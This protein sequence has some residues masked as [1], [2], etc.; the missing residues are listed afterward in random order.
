MRA[1][2]AHREAAHPAF[3]ARRIARRPGGHAALASAIGNRA[4]CALIARDDKTKTPA[5]KAR[6][7]NYALA[8]KQNKSYGQVP[9]EAAPW[10]LGWVGKLATVAPDLDALW[11]AGQANEFADAVAALQV[12][13][14]SKGK[15]VD[16]VLGPT[17]W[18][19]LAGLGEG[20]ASL[21]VVENTDGLCYMATQRRFEGGTARATGKKFKLPKGATKKTFDTII[22]THAGKLM[23]IEEQYR[24]TGAAGA[25]VYSG[26]GTF[27]SETD[28][29]A[30]KLQTGAALQVWAYKDSY[31]L[32]RKGEFTDKDGKTRPITKDDADFL[33]TSY[34]FLRYDDTTNEKMLV[35][36]HSGVEWVSKSEWA[37]WVAANPGVTPAPAATKT[38]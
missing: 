2:L 16:G 27:V 33:G 22:A 1:R 30:G 26:Q 13:Q 9:S 10:G 14:G 18:S 37:V 17:T 34:V 35:R 29:W 6:K 36:H 7:L 31:D 23:E 3:A 24:A 12:K 38:P 8:E 21:P 4:F 11:R 25:L 28:I 20:M 32:L 5:K 15:A 19:R